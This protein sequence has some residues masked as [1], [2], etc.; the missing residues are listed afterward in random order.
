M[1]LE[2]VGDLL[3]EPLLYLQPAG[4][5]LHHA[6]Q[7]RQAENARR[8]DVAD[9]GDPVERQQMVLAQR[10]ERNVAGQHQL[11]VALVVG[12]RCQVERSRRQQL[13]VRVR[14]PPG[15]VG[16]V[17]ARGIMTEGHQQIRDG[18]FRCVEIDR[19]LRHHP[20]ARYG[21]LQGRGSVVANERGHRT[22]R[23]EACRTR[24]S[25]V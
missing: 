16:Q 4:E 2:P 3:G 8:R 17:F 12:E 14:H 24:V 20:Q 11:V 18:L 25:G 13:G 10:L 6:G 7:L 9:V 19:R 1:L 5:Q 21:V 23:L 22:P 15:R